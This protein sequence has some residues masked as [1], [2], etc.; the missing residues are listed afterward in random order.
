M[1]SAAAL[2]GSRFFHPCSQSKEV[3]ASVHAKRLETRRTDRE[4]GT[5]TDVSSPAAG[6]N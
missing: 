3:S 1:F 5:G 4:V 2:G 6:M